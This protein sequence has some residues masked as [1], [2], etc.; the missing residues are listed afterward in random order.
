MRERFRTSALGA[1]AAGAAFAAAAST[2][3][4]RPAGEIL[5][6]GRTAG[7]R[8][9][10]PLPGQGGTGLSPARPMARARFLDHSDRIEA[11]LCRSFGMRVRIVPGPGEPEPRAVAVR[12]LHPV[13]TGPGGATGAEDDF[14]SAVV[15]GQTYVG[16]T[17][18]HD[19]ELRPGPWTIAVSAG[20]APV[21]VK[22]FE[23]VPPPPGAPAS[24][25]G[26]ETS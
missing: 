12:V 7:T 24:D 22:R 2:A 1:L 5:D 25:C 10:A 15:F 19:W 4:A 26:G 6:F 23:V 8:A 18:E 13:F 21:A 16:F 20:G 9:A 3:A 11:R 17:F 14:A